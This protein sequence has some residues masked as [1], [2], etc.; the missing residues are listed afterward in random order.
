MGRPNLSAWCMSRMALRYPSGCG[1][2][3]LRRMFSLVSRPFC[4]PMTVTGTPSSRAMPPTMA[5]SSRTHA[6]AVQLEEIIKNE[7]DVIQRR[8]P[9]RMAGQLHP[10]PRRQVREN[11]LPQ[12]VRLLLQR[13]DLRGQ[14]NA[15]LVD[16]GLQLFDAIFQLNEGPLPL[17]HA[18]GHQP[19]LLN[20][21]H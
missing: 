16:E 15:P 18:V 2:P 12:A 5:S 9:L 13:G 3:K 8:G 20:V 17:E 4:G 19:P 10:L 7:F 21:R 6:V 14:I 1:K 11:F